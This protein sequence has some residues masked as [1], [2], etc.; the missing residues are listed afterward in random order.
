MLWLHQFSQN[1]K[2]LLFFYTLEEL[3]FFKYSR[4]NVHF[5]GIQRY[6]RKSLLLEFRKRPQDMGFG[7][8]AVF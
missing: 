1:N 4:C 6:G 2:L 7:E 8:K 5:G 3:K